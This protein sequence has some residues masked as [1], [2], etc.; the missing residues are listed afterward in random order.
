MFNSVNDIVM[1]FV[2]ISPEG[3][4]IYNDCDEK[5]GIVF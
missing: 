5:D 3:S 1:C 2:Y 4:P